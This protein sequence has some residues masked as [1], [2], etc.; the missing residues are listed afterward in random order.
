MPGSRRLRWYFPWVP[1]GLLVGAAALVAALLLL[2][3]GP[4]AQA[5]PPAPQPTGGFQTTERLVLTVTLPATPGGKTRGPL[6]VEIVDRQG[7]VAAGAE[8]EVETGADALTERFE[9]TPPKGPADGLTVRCRFG[10]ES[11]EVPMSKVLLAKAHETALSSGQEFFAGSPAV[12]R[13]EAH[14]V[15]SLSETV[16]LPGAAVTVRL[17][18]KDGKVFP[19]YSGKAGAG[20]VAA[21]KFQVPNV[22]AGSYKLEVATRSALGEEK[23]ERDVKVKSAPRVL[24]VTDKPLYQPGQLIH[25][26]AL[27]LSAFDL[28]PAAGAALTFEVEDAKGNKVFKYAT[29]T[30][31]HGIVSADFQLADE[32]NQGDYRVRAV[33][34]DQQAE[35]TVTVKPYVLPKFKAEVKADKSYYL[36]KETVKAELQSDYFFGKP[37]AGAKV[38]VKASTFDVAFKDFQTWEGKTDGQGHAKFEVKL[39]DY[40]VGQPLAGGNALVRLEVKVT[41]T[42]DHTETVSRTYPVSAQPIN[43]SLIPEGGRLVPGL[44]NRLF[45]AALYPDG[46][47]AAGCEVKVWAGNAAK[48]EPLA[49]LKTNE[50]GLAELKL[51]P[52][53]KQFRQGPWEMRTVEMLGG[54]APNVWGPKQLFD[55]TARAKDTKGNTAQTT[56]QLS[57]E[58]FGENVLLR[59]DKAV[60][61]GGERMNVD[62]RSSAG[63]PTLYLDVV[64]NG[65]TLL[66]QW[67]DVKDGKA[68]HKLDLPPAAFGTLEVHAYQMLASGEVV[69]DAR[70]VY[71]NPASDL[72]V[73]VKPDKDVY[74]PG[75]QGSI[76]FQVTDSAGKPAAAALGILVVDEAVY[77]LQE[78][79]PGLEKVFFTLQQELLKPQAQAVYKP[80]QTLDTL[81]REPVLADARQQVAEALLAPVRPKPPARWEVHPALERR[82]KA[83]AL[84]AQV[85]FALYQYASTGKPVLAFDKESRTWGFRPGL[86]DEL[87]KVG[88]LNKAQLTDPVGGKLTLEGMARL[89]K[90]FTPQ[91]LGEALTLARTQQLTWALTNYA[92]TNR[93]KFF[94]DGKWT[95]PEGVLADAAKQQ[96]LQNFWLEDAWGRPIRLTRADK[97][98]IH[99]QAIAQFDTYELIS[100]GPD[101]K[102]GTAD[103]VRIPDKPGW[104]AWGQAQ[105]WWLADEARQAQQLAWGRRLR[106]RREVFQNGMMME[107]ARF[108]G[109]PPGAP[110]GMGGAGFAGGF[111]G[112]APAPMAAARDGAPML[113][114]AEAK[115]VGAPAGAKADG[116]GAAPPRLREFFPETLFWQPALITDER[117]EATLPLTFADSITTWRLTASASSRAGLLGGVSAPLRVFQDFFVDL[118]LPVALTQNDEVAFPVAVYNYLKGP[119]TVRLDLQPEQW[120]E[121]ADGGGLSRS[122]DLKAGEVTSVKFRIRAKRIGHF[123]L[124]VKAT[125]SKMSDAVKRGIDVLPDGKR[126]EQVVSDRLKG[127]VS[128]TIT[129]PESAIP[130]ASKLIVKVYPGVMSQVLEGAEGLLRLPGG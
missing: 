24:L 17:H 101:G 129:I 94:K 99:T 43:V 15:K 51:T 110:G 46:S 67:L 80:N 87:V 64:K 113:K 108:G 28:K 58:P 36:P 96:G 74:L 90:D 100:A 35:K 29:K 106:T 57:S 32:V 95:L 63:L 25:I 89:E 6:K 114:K 104:N 39:P 49:T 42:A 62:V 73:A 66:T 123:P 3:G 19:L 72:K 7:K 97:K 53:Q 98:R 121:L 81:V 48:G 14:G 54:T 85:G 38:T 130:D 55:V 127:K 78:M 20:G 92:N 4:R 69:R 128:Q 45:A 47:P 91:R 16:P 56:A 50:A 21:V 22:P 44:E 111:R 68:A 107:R 120:F 86:L 83:E 34:G 41:D 77:A 40:F 119:Q 93:A 118:D 31:E 18:G 84:V 109:G 125:G 115:A 2:P 71:V 70:V 59:L 26:R 9:F 61:K 1:L 122:I 23:L 112:D 8:R 11:A 30:T 88:Y 76:R 82:Q 37:V 79:Q 27:A 13:C 5:A 60:Y 102:A 12:L 75:A 103:D 33:L 52:E 126:V 117:G 65:Q 10:K 105:V 124:T 116:G